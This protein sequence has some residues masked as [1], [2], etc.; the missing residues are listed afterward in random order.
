MLAYSI[1][2]AKLPSPRPACTPTSRSR[3]EILTEGVTLRAT[4][5]GKESLSTEWDYPDRKGG[6]GGVG[7]G[8]GWS[9]EHA[10]TRCQFQPKLG[11]RQ[12]NLF[13]IG[14]VCGTGGEQRHLSIPPATLAVDPELCEARKQGSILT[15]R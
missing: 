1:V 9:N 13:G 7:V 4:I 8:G 11:L 3:S 12:R 14:H 6:K 15:H 10:R 2:K 5:Q